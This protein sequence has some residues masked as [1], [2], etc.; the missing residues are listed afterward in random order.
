MIIDLVNELA[1]TSAFQLNLSSNYEI[2]TC[3]GSGYRWKGKI[4]GTKEKQHGKR[5]KSNIAKEMR[6][7]MGRTTRSPFSFA[8]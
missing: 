8:E 7:F 1:L 2:M 6:G 4:Y 5:Q 3:D